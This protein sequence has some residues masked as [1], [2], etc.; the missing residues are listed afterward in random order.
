MNW[1]Y[2]LCIVVVAGSVVG[3]AQTVHFDEFK[4]LR[5][6]E[7]RAA[8]RSAPAEQKE[9]LTKIHVHLSLRSMYGESGLKQ[10]KESF[11]A[12]SRG[13]VAIED[14]FNLQDITW[15][16][17]LSGI[18]E[19]N[20]R[21]GIASEKRKEQ[22]TKIDAALDVIW[23]RRTKVHA[24][25]FNLAPS[26]EALQVEEEAEKLYK[27][28]GEQV[29]I[30]MSDAGRQV[31]MTQVE[32]WDK[33]ID[34]IFEKLKILPMLKPEEAQKAFDEFPEET[35]L[36]GRTFKMTAEGRSPRNE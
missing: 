15:Q 7:R 9:A 4:K 29:D 11:V 12:W 34:Q 27:E 32:V 25:F 13:F 8:I 18:Y 23:K 31:T 19:A 28:I 21:D 16:K 30:I 22:E 35:V 3:D 33:S 26:A 6:D 1:K 20:H 2:A 24:L 5:S 10:L 36:R 17:Y 14:L